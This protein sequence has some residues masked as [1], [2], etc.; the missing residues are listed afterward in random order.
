[1]EGAGRIFAG[2]YCRARN[3]RA[4]FAGENPFP[5]T[6]GGMVCNLL[7]IAGTLTEKGQNR[8]DY[9]YGRVADP[10]GVFQIRKMRPDAGLKEILAGID[11]PAFVTVLGQARAT[12]HAADPAPYVE[13]LEIREVDRAVRDTWIIRTAELTC[14][15]LALLKEALRSGTG[16]REFVLAIKEFQIDSAHI[17]PLA[18][19]ACRAIAQVADASPPEGI[20]AEAREKVLSI[21]RDSAGKKGLPLDELIR[22]AGTAGIDEKAVREAVRTLLEED[23]CYQPAREVYKPL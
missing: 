3:V 23:E 21:I 11:I 5:L 13:L 20:H 14:N 1:M 19:M 2:E 9:L 10:T 8:G 12:A 22:L 6:P 7:F 17:G 18:D 16:S 15:R 4:D